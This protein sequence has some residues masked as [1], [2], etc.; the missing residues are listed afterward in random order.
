MQRLITLA[1]VVLAMTAA[2]ACKKR[3]K[4]PYD[5]SS[6]QATV[7]SLFKAMNKKRI[8]ADLQHLMSTTSLLKEWQF[9]CRK[10]CYGASFKIVRSE[11]KN[12]SKTI[13]YVDFVIRIGDGRKLRRN[14]QPFILDKLADQWLI[15]E[16][17]L[18]TSKK[19]TA[20]PVDAGKASDAGP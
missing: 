15:G 20:P 1:V 11:T 2:L 4:P 9:R 3:D 14:A 5:V 13:V 10:G 6:P 18:R 19:T 8:P 12:P 7:A 17:G 16:I